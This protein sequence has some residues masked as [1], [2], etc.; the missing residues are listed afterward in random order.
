MRGFEEAIVRMTWRLDN[1]TRDTRA[2]VRST[3]VV[4]LVKTPSAG[5]A[6]GK[7]PHANPRTAIITG[8]DQTA[9]VPGVISCTY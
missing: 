7:G 2:P 3:K 4:R 6:Q 9:R 8:C 1:N 5:C